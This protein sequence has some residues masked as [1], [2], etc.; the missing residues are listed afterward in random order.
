MGPAG[1]GGSGQQYASKQQWKDG[2]RLQWQQQHQRTCVLV[3]IITC[4]VRQ[5]AAARIQVW[6]RIKVAMEISLLQR[7]CSSRTP[8]PHPVPSL[9]WPAPLL[10]LA[11][12]FRVRALILKP[13]LL[14][15][16]P[17]WSSQQQSSFSLNFHRKAV[18]EAVHAAW[19]WH[20]SAAGL[21]GN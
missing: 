14:V 20:R 4:V 21:Q 9:R 11:V 15:F 13:W 6:E 1:G 12:G 17:R 10:Q 18:R 8:L 5:P 19:G 3:A 16:L 2:T 7:C